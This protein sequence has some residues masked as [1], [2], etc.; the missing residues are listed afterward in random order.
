MNNFN[1]DNEKA[2][3]VFIKA[4]ELIANKPDNLSNLQSYLDYHFPEWLKKY[5]S[6]PSDLASELLDFATME[7]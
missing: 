7:I 3:E 6:T 4:I 2:A 1:N 5:A